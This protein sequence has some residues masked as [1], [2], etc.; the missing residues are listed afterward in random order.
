MPHYA[1]AHTYS[2]DIRNGAG[3]RMG[4]V[5]EFDTVEAR[6]EWCASGPGVG[7]DYR[8]REA[9]DADDGDIK[10]FHRI[11]GIIPEADLTDLRFSDWI[12]A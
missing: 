8:Y 9:L 1:I 4:L 10:Y 7:S 3:H 5:V 2:A 6:D 11:D 12:G